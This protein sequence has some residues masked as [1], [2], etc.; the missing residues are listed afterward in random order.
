MIKKSVDFHL[1]LKNFDWNLATVPINLLYSPFVLF[2]IQVSNS[3][4]GEIF[5]VETDF[6]QQ[7]SNTLYLLP[8]NTIYHKRFQPKLFIS[9][10]FMKWTLHLPTFLVLNTNEPTFNNQLGTHGCQMHNKTALTFLSLICN[11]FICLNIFEP[12]LNS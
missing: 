7:Q 11:K 12:W 10:N 6:L 8:M 1:G 2:F 5:S 9:W 4:F 3:L